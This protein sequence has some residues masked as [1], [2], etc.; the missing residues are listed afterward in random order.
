MMS[1]RR[2]F[3]RS[4]DSCPNFSPDLSLT[5]VV[6]NSKVTLTC[7]NSF[8]PLTF[9]LCDN[10]SRTRFAALFFSAL[11]TNFSPFPNLASPVNSKTLP[12]NAFFLVAGERSNSV[13]NDPESSLVWTSLCRRA[14]FWAFVLQCIQYNGTKFHQ[15]NTCLLLQLVFWLT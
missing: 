13:F 8:F 4:D 11:R 14:S 9:C 15:I 5:S 12:A 2:L 7:S 6:R 10:P 1:L 3:S